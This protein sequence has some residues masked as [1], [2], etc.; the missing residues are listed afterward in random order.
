[1]LLE[2]V[3]AITKLGLP[4]L[5][6]SWLILSRLYVRGILHA[7]D[8]AEDTAAQLKALKNEKNKPPYQGFVHSRW[9]KFGG[10]FYGLAALW[11]F[12]VIEIEQAIEFFTEFPGWVGLFDQN[13]ISLI[14]QLFVNQIKNFVAAMVWFLYWGAGG[15]SIGL[16][17][18]TAYASF[19][20]GD[21][22]AR[23]STQNFR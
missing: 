8:D 19:Q 20:A 2:A 12:V 15:A 5:V 22:L 18:L 16:W 17:I 23:K 13:I 7:T 10:G 4:V 9:M 1:M 14:V 21:A 11:T 6:L 3:A